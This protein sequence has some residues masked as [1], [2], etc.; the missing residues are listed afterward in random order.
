[1][2]RNEDIQLQLMTVFQ[3]ELQEHASSLNR[4]FLA[5]EQEQDPEK[6]EALLAELFRAAHSLKGAARGVGVTDVETLAHK[7]ED[8]MSAMRQGELEP[9]PVIFD[10][11]FPIVDALS[12]ALSA[13]QAGERF[14]IARR[15]SLFETLQEVITGD[16]APGPSQA[17]PRST[18]T[19]ASSASHEETIRVST[20]KLDFIM[21]DVSELLVARMRSEQRLNELRQLQAQLAER[22]RSWWGVRAQFHQLQNLSGGA[23]VDFEKLQAVLDFIR[24]NDSHLKSA[25]N[26]AKELTRSFDEDHRRFSMLSDNL[27][28]GV[29]RV[30]MLPISNLFDTFPRLVRDLART[31]GKEVSLQVTGADTEVDRQI[32]ET[33]KDPLIHLLRNAVDH[34]IRKPELRAAVGKSSVGTIELRAFPKGNSILIEIIDDGAGIDLRA[35]RQAAIRRGLITQENAHERS[36]PETLDLIFTSGLSTQEEVNELSGR[37]VG[38]DVVRQNIERLHGIV[39]VESTFGEKTK[40]TLILPLT[41]ATSHV[42]LIQAASQVVAVPTTAVERI[43]RIDSTQ[44]HAIEGRPAIQF[45]QRWLPLIDLNQVLGFTT[46]AYSRSDSTKLRVVILGTAEKRLAFQVDALHNT[47]EVVVKN[48]GAQLR[49]VPNVAGATILGS[50]EVVI[51]LNIADLMKSTHAS[52]EIN[53]L[54]PVDLATLHHNRVLVV[55]D[56]ITTRTL[57]KNILE[58]AGYQ[59]VVAANGQEAWGLVQHE[60]LDIV[61]SDIAMPRMNGFELTQ[62]IKS[63]PRYEDIP[64]VLVTSLESSSDKIRGMEA[65]ADAYVFKSG[66][67]QQ[68]LLETIERLIG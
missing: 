53:T 5:L 1:M 63:D 28:N 16:A 20:A 9:L 50:S 11:L 42:L 21:D 40:F 17:A 45:N 66:F 39:K 30:R 59:V 4:G 15:D 29:R 25:Q 23:K 56:S 36:D 38:L 43:L 24:E 26:R 31:Q 7:L 3:A 2:A 6:R 13:Y 44:I 19:T 47:Q 55:D 60:M 61:I 32:L 62:R 54:A 46:R 27:Q 58:N 18:L 65:G 51:I 68:N 67:D 64:V 52:V 14:A 12:E 8:I 35:V 57:E 22:Q 34:G 33:M 10:A 49:R 48:L 37:G 41:L